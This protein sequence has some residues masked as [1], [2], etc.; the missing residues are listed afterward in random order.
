L[1]NNQIYEPMIAG[2]TVL[3]II[4]LTKIMSGL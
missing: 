4:Q 1:P 3:W 2:P